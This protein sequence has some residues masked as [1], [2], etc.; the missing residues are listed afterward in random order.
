MTVIRGCEGTYL[1]LN[2]LDYTICNEGIL[3]KYENGKVVKA[4]LVNSKDCFSD[5]IHCMMVHGHAT[6]DG[7]Y[8]ITKVN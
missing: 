8:E 5:R 2:N 4:V 3:D 7:L 1:R 6:A